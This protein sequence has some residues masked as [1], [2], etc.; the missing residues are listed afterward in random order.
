MGEKGNRLTEIDPTV[1]FELLT[2]GA[3]ATF[4]E[5]VEAH[6]RLNLHTK[7]NDQQLRTSVILPKGTGKE[8]RIAVITQGE[9]L[10]EATSAG[11][12]I[13]GSDELIEKIY[14]GF[15]DFDLLVATPD[16][17]TKI[18]RLGR[19]LGPK[20]LMPNPKIRT[21][22]FFLNT[23]INE[24]KVGKLELRADKAGIV[25]LGIGKANFKTEELIENL[26]S[27]VE[28]IESNR[29]SGAKGVYWKN[30]FISSTMGPGFRIDINKIKKK[31]KKKNHKVK[32]KKKKKK[33][34]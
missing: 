12:E 5:P 8:I 16:M 25:H 3:T 1:A 15:L 23:T 9:K 17:M 31:K 6:A 20:G 26:K 30:L 10:A 14:S 34:K 28:A 18:A 29:P 4:H 7:Y 32:K 2:K 13:V 19:L 11:A 24:F 33:K 22:T 21:V 27:L